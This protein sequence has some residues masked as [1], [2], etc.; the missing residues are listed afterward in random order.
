MSELRARSRFRDIS[1]QLCHAI[2]LYT[3]LLVVY[4]V[5]LNRNSSEFIY[6]RSLLKL[7]TWLTKTS[8]I[9]S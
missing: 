9:S 2:M 8:S 5:I 1:V 4:R 7:D 6:S 3:L